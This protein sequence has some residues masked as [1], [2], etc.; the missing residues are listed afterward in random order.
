LTIITCY[1]AAAAKGDTIYDVPIVS[2]T[3]T[4]DPQTWIS[5]FFINVVSE[6][7]LRLTAAMAK[8][9]MEFIFVD[10]SLYYVVSFVASIALAY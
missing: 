2:D 3:F 5:R 10:V 6:G 1:I 9:S 4:K 7:V 8:S